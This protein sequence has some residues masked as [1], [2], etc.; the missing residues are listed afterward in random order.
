MCANAAMC[1]STRHTV[2]GINQYGLDLVP[3]TEEFPDCCTAGNC[4]GRF[5]EQGSD[6]DPN[7]LH[8]EAASLTDTPQPHGMCVEVRQGKNES[9]SSQDRILI[10]PSWSRLVHLTKCRHPQGEVGSRI[11]PQTASK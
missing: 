3:F 8:S 10:V 1:F 11:P 7:G 5:T 4:S 9:E 2:R 6:A